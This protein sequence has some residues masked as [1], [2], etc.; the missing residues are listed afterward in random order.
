[1]N[2]GFLVATVNASFGT[3]LTAIG[4]HGNLE[5]SKSEV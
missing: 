4:C 2:S 1:M 3:V 5:E